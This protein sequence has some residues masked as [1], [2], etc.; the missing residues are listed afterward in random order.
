M[1]SQHIL[2]TTFGGSRH[3][4][5]ILDNLYSRNRSNLLSNSNQEQPIAN[6]TF[7]HRYL[8]NPLSI[9]TQRNQEILIDQT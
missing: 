8:A 4:I 6:E 2:P 1:F 3:N 9:E 7:A 5:Q